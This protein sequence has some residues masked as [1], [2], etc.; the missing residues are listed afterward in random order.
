MKFS[1]NFFSYLGKKSKLKIAAETIEVNNF[2]I[3][4]KYKSSTKWQSSIS[5][6]EIKREVREFIIEW[7]QTIYSS[8]I[9]A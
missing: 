9:S 5:G 6:W 2:T 4:K 3:C 1:N 8:I 7:T